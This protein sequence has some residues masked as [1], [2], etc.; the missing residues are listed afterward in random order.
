LSFHNQREHGLLDRNLIL[1][2]FKSFET[3]TVEKIQNDGQQGQ[4]DKLLSACESG[5]ER[6]FLTSLIDLQIKL[7][8]SGQTT[9]FD[10]TTQAPIAK[11]DFFYNSE[12]LAIF[13]DGSPHD[14]DYIQNDDEL[15][16][17]KLKE[18]GYRVFAVRYDTF[19][20]DMKKLA[21]MV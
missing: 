13:V 6:K 9:L 3:V 5:L 8:D 4:L 2:F 12:N 18:Q 11:P 20:E 17:N 10:K 21:R 19:D 16:R 7:P 1:P 15:K 14:K